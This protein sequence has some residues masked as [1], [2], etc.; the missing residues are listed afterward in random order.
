VKTYP[1]IPRFSGK[2]RDLYTFDKLDGSNLRFEWTKKKG[3]HKFGTRK[4]LFDETDIIFGSAIPLFMESLSE[5]IGK[6]FADKNWQKTIVFVEFWGH[7]SFAGVHIEDD[8]K[9]LTVIDISIHRLG[10]LPPKEFLTYFEEFGPAYLGYHRWNKEFVDL[11]HSGE[12]DLS[13]SF[14]GIVGK[15]MQKNVMV[16]YKAKTREWIN[17]VRRSYN[18]L[19]AQEIIDS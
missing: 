15:T 7:E 9:F 17:K 16:M 18:A 19:E 3:W 2:S 5:P 13:I 14:E 11:V 10:M 4:R 8:P 12:S 6:V 1:S